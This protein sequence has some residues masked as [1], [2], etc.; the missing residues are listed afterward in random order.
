MLSQTGACIFGF[1]CTALAE[2]K[3]ATWRG[4]LAGPAARLLLLGFCGIFGC[5]ERI[6]LPAPPDD[7][8]PTGGASAR[9]FDGAA[10]QATS[11]GGDGAGLDGEAGEAGASSRPPR[12][13]QPRLEACP[14]RRAPS[15]CR[16]SGDSTHGVRL[17]GTLLER[18]VTR[19]GGVLDVDEAGNIRCAACDCGD[20]GQA[21]VIDCPRLVI[22]P[23]LINLHDHL[24]YAGTPPLEHPGDLYQHRSDW[25]LG[26]NGHAPLPF[27]GRASTAQV[28]AQELRM[29]MGGATSTVGAGGR[30]GLVR[31]LDVAGA[32]EG[33]LPGLIR[34]ETF[35]LDDASGARDAAACEFGRNPDTASVGEHAQAYV[36]HLGEGTDARAQHELRCAL[37]SK[38]LLRQNSAVVHAMALSRSDAE[39]LAARGASVV[40]SPRSNLDLYGSTAPVGLLSSL[41]VRIAL[42][43]DWLASGSMNL[44]RELACARRYDDEVLGGY[45]DA[46]QLLR[47]VTD[48]AA[49]ALG[50]ERR[51]GELSAGLVADIAVFDGRDREARAAVV[52]A[53][54]ADVRLVLRA[55]A[56]LYGDAEL[57]AAFAGASA[58]EELLVCGNPRRVCVAETGVAL[59]EIRQAGEAVYPLFSCELPP[60][61]PHCAAL[62]TAECPSGELSCDPPPPAPPWDA[63]DSDSDEVADIA[64]NCARVP[65]ADQRDADGDGRG[66]ACDA[67]PATN[68]GLTPCAV[69]IAE[70]R[71]PA[72]RLPLGS[73]VLLSG[74][75]V[76]ALRAQGSKGFYL[77]DGTHAPYSG[78]FV[79]T[80]SAKPSVDVDELVSVQGYFTSYQGTDQ[81]TQVEVLS[82][83]RAAT[84]Y[85]P[86]EVSLAELADGASSAAALA[87]L[88]VRISGAEVQDENPDAPEDY[89]ET[90]LVGGLRL[91]DALF[92]DLD[93]QFAVGARFRSLQ[94]IAGFSFSH[95]KLWPRLASDVEPE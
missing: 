48:D 54:T 74:V 66:D 2:S 36:A 51:L 20:A 44:L 16:I 77:E 5:R 53:T 89:D 95:Q 60:R 29:V 58:C 22:A 85:A 59:E 21:L 64:D 9:D 25:R 93:N 70:L 42:G 91:D 45:F 40:W 56:P 49:W 43:T 75:R 76:T 35:P 90:A 38:D 62:V 19:L 39:R 61:E 87:S 65:N 83:Q 84:A 37:G 52:E 8:A 6:A 7:P 68:P 46:A 81:L 1:A 67:C 15:S 72:S 86:L 24:G 28:L 31:N 82:R 26:V 69:T 10:A 12:S 47:M 80:A 23:G 14:R 73:A 4:R 34:A 32:S 13:N 30:R 27:V 94:G 92:G 18:R 88:F 71:S 3:R 17:L 63:R 57:V 33:L 50:L 79:Y 78:I 11:A 41:G 55:G